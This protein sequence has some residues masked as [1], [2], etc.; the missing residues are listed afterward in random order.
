MV[1]EQLKTRVPPTSRI[2]LEHSL[3]NVDKLVLVVFGEDGEFSTERSGVIVFA[4][5]RFTAGRLHQVRVNPGS[6]KKE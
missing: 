5:I 6:G 2:R 4:L 1:L 3:P